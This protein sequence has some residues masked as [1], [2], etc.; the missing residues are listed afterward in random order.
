MITLADRRKRGI[1]ML[2]TAALPEPL[3]VAVRR[4]LLARLELARARRAEL[5]IIGH[6]KSGTT[7]VRTMVS[8]LYHVRHGLP[9]DVIVRSDELHRLDRAAPRI[10]VTSGYYSFRGITG[11]YLSAD[12]PRTE[13]HDK[14]AVLLARHPCDIAVSW[15]IQFTKRQSAARRELINHFIEHPID[16][17]TISMWDFVM[18]SD[19]GLPFLIDY[20]NTW[21]RNVARMNHVIIRYEDLRTQPHETLTRLVALLDPTFTDREI[22]EAVAFGSFDNL[23][24]LEQSG[25]FPRGGLALQNPADPDTYKVRRGRIGG[26]RD[27]FSPEQVAQMDALVA[28]RLS[29]TLG[30]GDAHPGSALTAPDATKER[31]M[32]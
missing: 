7:W 32:A 19:V 2:A 24:K 16:H 12:G 31:E 13:L 27:Y 14:P 29:P 26:Y 21:E 8:H 6:P 22:A 11:R 25:F 10:L 9:P 17:T 18:H 23:R 1:I 4:A 20:L 30:Y 15:Y 5:L 28:E 3:R